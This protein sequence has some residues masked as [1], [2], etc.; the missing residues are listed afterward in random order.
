MSDELSLEFV[1][2]SPAFEMLVRGWIMIE[3]EF[4]PADCYEKWGL[5]TKTLPAEVAQL[6]QED[7][8]LALLQWIDRHFDD[9]DPELMFEAVCLLYDLEWLWGHSGGSFLMADHVARAGPVMAPVLMEHLD[10]SDFRLS[11]LAVLCLAR[12]AAGGVDPCDLLPGLAAKL[13][14]SPGSAAYVLFRMG[15]A[16]T[17]PLVELLREADDETRSEACDGCVMGFADTPMLFEVEV[18]GTRARPD[19]ADGR[20]L[21][22]AP[23]CGTRRCRRGNPIR[24]NGQ[25]GTR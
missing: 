13:P 5:A 20:S 25:P 3:H 21:A 6:P 9:D 17:E 10:A 12:I 15:R 2:P 8:P 7:Q 19:G 14:S 1:A 22:R 4:G 16:G 23:R 11:S 18:L 24:R